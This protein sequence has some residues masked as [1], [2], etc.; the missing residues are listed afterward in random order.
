MFAVISAIVVAFKLSISSLLIISTGD[1]PSVGLALIYEP[2]TTTS[3]TDSSCALMANELNMRK[4]ERHRTNNFFEFC[5]S[6]P[7][8]V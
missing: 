5:I 1:A 8:I 4:I 3:S 7:L 6:S 2:V